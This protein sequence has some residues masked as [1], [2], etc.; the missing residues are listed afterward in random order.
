MKFEENWRSSK[1]WTD[2][3]Q[4]HRLCIITTA[5]PAEFV[6]TAAKVKAP[7]WQVTL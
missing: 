1:V 5:H 7:L 4:T 3:G 6:Q 2:G